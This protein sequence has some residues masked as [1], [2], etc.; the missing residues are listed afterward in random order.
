MKRDRII[1]E[2]EDNKKILI[3]CCGYE[4]CLQKDILK[5]FPHYAI[6]CQIFLKR[7]YFISKRQFN[8]ENLV[9]KQ[10]NMI[11]IDYRDEFDY[12]IS[13]NSILMSSTEE[14][15]QVFENCNKALKRNGV[16]IAY[17]PSFESCLSLIRLNPQLECIL[18]LEDN[19]QVI[20][21]DT[22][23]TCQS[24]HSLESLEKLSESF[25]ESYVF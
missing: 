5:R 22:D 11:T 14:N 13:T 23:G 19:Q 12:V 2:L 15:H 25:N 16:L 7:C 6:F 20:K 21:D 4:V 17:L 10:E 24:F 8:C 3:L 9:F 18:N 1:N